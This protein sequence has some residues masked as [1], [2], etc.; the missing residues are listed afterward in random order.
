M[1]DQL[2]LGQKASSSV[3]YRCLLADPPWPE[4][5]GGVIK[6]GADRHYGLIK[7]K[8][9][10]RDVMLA[11]GVWT[12]ATNAHA[13]IWYTDNYIEWAFWLMRELGFEPK[14]TF[15]WIKVGY[16]FADD[17]LDALENG[18]LIPD[19]DV[20]RMGIG[21]YARGCK[22]G[23]LFGVRG[24]GQSPD[25]WTG[26]RSVRDVVFA[27]HV[28][29]NGKRVHSAKPA[30]TYERIEQVSRGPRV[31]LFARSG[32]VGWDSWGDQAPAAETTR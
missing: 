16:D 5:G 15:Q 17:D 8:E 28:I 30:R 29:E 18:T 22:E 20:L 1:G 3:A 32:R 21:Q 9:E 6:R 27:P 13:H 31:E 26:D 10:I 12:P 2:Q 25:V 7:S 11:S 4:S 19:E 14:R 24:S 23:W